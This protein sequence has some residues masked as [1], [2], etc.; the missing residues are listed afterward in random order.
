VTWGVPTRDVPFGIAAA[1]GLALANYALL[2]RAPRGWLV[3]GVRTVYRDALVPLFGRLDRA[4][5]LIVAAA[6]GLGE[7][8][9]FRGVVQPVLGWLAASVV[10]G[11][12]HV[13]GR[14]MLAFG[15]WATVMGLALGGLALVTGGL[16]APTV[17]HGLYDALALEYIRRTSA[18]TVGGFHPE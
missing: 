17:A 16:L 4:S 2:T 9:F 6:A 1:L 10:F 7:E 11:L 3:D 15:A 5:I 14:Q 8:W 18:T 12:A 13:G